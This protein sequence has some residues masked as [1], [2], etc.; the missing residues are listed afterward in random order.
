MFSG[1]LCL[2][3]TIR[4]VF[5]SIAILC[6]VQKKNDSIHNKNGKLCLGE[7]LWGGCSF[8]C[9]C[10][11]D[12]CSSQGTE[13]LQ[14]M[15]EIDCIFGTPDIENFYDMHAVCIGVETENCI[16][17]YVR[18]VA[19]VAMG[20]EIPS[21]K[22]TTLFC[23]I[24][25]QPFSSLDERVRDQ[26]MT[27]KSAQQQLQPGRVVV[28]RTMVRAP[29]LYLCSFVTPA[30]T[31]TRGG[32]HSFHGTETRATTLEHE[33]CANLIQSSRMHS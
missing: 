14:S 3:R 12:V 6:E 7:L 9:Y 27:S 28:V 17:L 31:T 23:C 32:V 5:L 33:C 10:W 30:T 1:A 21:V 8:L 26:I 11:A 25:S 4:S 20:I 19:H 22:N 16:Q 15:K 29:V 18:V 24:A 13:I 2:L